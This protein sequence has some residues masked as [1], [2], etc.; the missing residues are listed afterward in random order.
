MR[1]RFW[2]STRIVGPLR[3]IA[4]RS[5]LRPAYRFRHGQ[6]ST[7]SAFLHWG[8]FR[9]FV[10]AGGRARARVGSWAP[11]LLVLL[12]LGAVVFAVWLA[13]SGAVR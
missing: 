3:L 10:G 11:T 4:S 8:P 9:Y 6:V 13:A 1:G 5:G 7:R 2:A 12:T